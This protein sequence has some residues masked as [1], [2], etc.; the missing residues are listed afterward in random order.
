MFERPTFPRSHIK[1]GF[2]KNNPIP[3]RIIAALLLI[4]LPI[5][6]IPLYLWDNLEDLWDDMRGS[7]DDLYRIAIGRWV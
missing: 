2:F 1:E 3:A 4:A 6:Q 5:I 7:A